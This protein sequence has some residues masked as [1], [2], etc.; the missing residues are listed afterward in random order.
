MVRTP[1]KAMGLRVHL[2]AYENMLAAG[3]RKALANPSSVR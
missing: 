2:M 3:L 1:E